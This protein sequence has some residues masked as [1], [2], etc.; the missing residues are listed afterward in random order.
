MS[1]ASQFTIPLLQPKS[2]MFYP[3]ENI[4]ELKFASVM[5]NADCQPNRIW[6][7]LEGKIWGTPMRD[8]LE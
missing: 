1:Y 2:F 4:S 7:H 3:Y 6:N 5:V 8:Y